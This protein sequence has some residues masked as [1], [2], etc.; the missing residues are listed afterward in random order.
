MHEKVTDDATLPTF[1]A[2]LPRLSARMKQL[3]AVYILRKETVE[4]NIFLKNSLNVLEE[5]LF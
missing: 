1:K 5:A 3:R 2:S 4:L